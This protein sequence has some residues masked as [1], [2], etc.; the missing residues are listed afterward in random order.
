MFDKCFYFVDLTIDL[1]SE[2][3]DVSRARARASLAAGPGALQPRSLAAAC[4][5]LVV[6]GEQDTHVW[7]ARHDSAD[8]FRPGWR[9]PRMARLGAFELQLVWCEGGHVVSELL[10]SKLGTSTSTH[11]H[12]RA[13]AR[14]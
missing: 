10:H 9:T 4:E 5:V 2:P 8:K 3:Y 12:Q 14:E 6:P 7:R 11:S 1:D 13:R